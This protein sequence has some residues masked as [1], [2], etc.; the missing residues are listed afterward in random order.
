MSQRS[1][2]WQVQLPEAD[3]ALSGA[4]LASVLAGALT[5]G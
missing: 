1:E 4:E 2:A 5:G 3:P